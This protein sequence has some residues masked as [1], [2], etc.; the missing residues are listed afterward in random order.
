M[1]RTALVVSSQPTSR[2]VLR[3]ITELEEEDVTYT[4]TYVL[5]KTRCHEG[6]RTAGIP[7][8]GCWRCGN[9]DHR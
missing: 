3:R 9:V 5:R 1:R 7:K 4:H 8:V 2:V 6:G